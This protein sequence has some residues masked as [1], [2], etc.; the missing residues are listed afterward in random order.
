MGLGELAALQAVVPPHLLLSWCTPSSPSTVFLSGT[1]SRQ[2]PATDTTA[3]TVM[4]FVLP[5]GFHID[6]SSPLSVFTSNGLRPER[7]LVWVEGWAC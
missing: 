4:A 2:L 1:R 6:L 5:A 7:G 3:I